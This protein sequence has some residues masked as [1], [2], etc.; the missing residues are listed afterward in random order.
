MEAGL[1]QVE[2]VKTKQKLNFLA[3]KLC[4]P[5]LLEVLC[6]FGFGRE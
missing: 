3:F 5:L 6:E 4:V 2:V 1:L